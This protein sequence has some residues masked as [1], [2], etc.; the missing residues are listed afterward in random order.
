MVQELL[1]SEMLEKVEGVVLGKCFNTAVAEIEIIEGGKAK[2]V[3][4]GDI[5]HFTLK[6]V[7]TNADEL[8]DEAV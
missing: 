1:A 6:V 3:R 2:L 5:S 7:E 4:Y 8:G